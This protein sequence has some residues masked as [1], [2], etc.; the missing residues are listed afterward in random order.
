MT[1]LWRFKGEPAPASTTTPF[2]DVNPSGYYMK[3][4]DWAVEAEITKG[5]TETTFGPDATCS[6]GQVVTFL[7]RATAAELA[8]PV[9]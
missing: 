9:E 5:L 4:V 7:Y 6:R 8:A 1:F 3:A 2:T